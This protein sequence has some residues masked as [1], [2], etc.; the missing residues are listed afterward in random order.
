MKENKSIQLNGT[1]TTI[2]DN[3]VQVII[4]DISG[5]YAQIYNQGYFD[6]EA[7]KDIQKQY[8]DTKLWRVLVLDN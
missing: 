1:N 8:F 2:S 4:L 6:K 3:L 5:V 7:V